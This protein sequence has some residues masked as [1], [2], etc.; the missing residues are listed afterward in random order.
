[1]EGD[2]HSRAPEER[3]VA[4][5]LPRGVEVREVV[6]PRHGA[7][8]E[9]ARHR[10]EPAHAAAHE[11]RGDPRLADRRVIRTREGEAHIGVEHE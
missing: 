7:D 6:H 9:H 10:E 5:A 4:I 2:A 11:E 1:M 8:G 3:A